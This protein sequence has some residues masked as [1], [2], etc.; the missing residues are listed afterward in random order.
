VVQLAKDDQQQAHPGDRHQRRREDDLAGEM[1]QL[2]K[3]D[4]SEPHV[5]ASNAEE[6]ET[7]K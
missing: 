7:L 2:A 6:K 1:V 3:D 4:Q 5:T